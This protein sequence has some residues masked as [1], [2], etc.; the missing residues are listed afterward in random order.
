MFSM[1]LPWFELVA[2]ASII[3]IALLVMV[4]VSGK[5][6]VGQ[7]TPF[8]LLVVMLL[9]ESVS[10]G[11]NGGDESVIG[12]LVAAATL[13][14]L[15]FL[16][17]VGTARSK[18]FET[19][20][21]GEPVLIAR[22][23]RLFH[24]VLRRNNVSKDDFDKALREADCTMGDVTFAFLESDGQISVHKSSREQCSEKGA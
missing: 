2:R 10:N 3:Y 21:E 5:R 1:Q 7:F 20:T 9:S 8:D 12:G 24:D 13:V 6:T 19:L 4:R 22:D 14:G 23:G 17:A 15:N 16:V 18:I 11:L